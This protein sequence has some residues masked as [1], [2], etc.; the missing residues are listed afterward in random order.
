MT[1]AAPVKRSS[2]LVTGASGFVG[3]QLCLMLAQRGWHVVAASRRL[4]SRRPVSGI[5]DIALPLSAQAAEWQKALASVRCVVHLAARV[6][7]IG[8]DDA[9]ARAYREVNVDGSRFVAEQAVRAGVRRFVFLSSIKV[10]GEGGCA[11]PYRSD[12]A[13]NP[14]D[15]YGR[16]KW[17]AEVALHEVCARAAMELVII[18]PPLV[19]GPG[20]RANFKRLMHLASLGLPLPLRGIDNRRSLISVW[21]LADFIDTC[22]RHEKAAG[23]TF[24]ISDGED[25]STPE[26]LQKLSRSMGRPSRLFR[27]PPRALRQLAR[28]AGLGAEMQRLCGSLVV[29]STPAREKLNW[30]PIVSTD[31]G[32]ARTVAA[33]RTER[34]G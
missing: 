16:S 4:C 5:D 25:L 2:A 23:E 18:R 33:F 28:L 19:Y 31:E 32:L 6:H 24:L 3:A 10:N 34:A 1:F 21:N 29:D 22:M 11:R 8:D 30:H 20:V 27:L 12:D 9:A 14:F 7:Q 26:L 17:D 13:P 15:P